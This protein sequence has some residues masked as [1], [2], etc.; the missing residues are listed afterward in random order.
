MI[1]PATSSR[2]RSIALL[3]IGFALATVAFATPASG[4]V[5]GTAEHLLKHLRPKTDARYYTKPAADAQFIKQS[6]AAGGDLAGTFPNPTIAANA[7]GSAEIG[8]SA[9][10]SVEIEDRQ[11]KGDDLAFN[12]I[13]GSALI[14]SGAV[15]S[16]DIQDGTIAS[17]D[18]NGGSVGATQLSGHVAVRTGSVLVPGNTPQNGSYET[19]RAIVVCQADE[20]RVGGG[21]GWYPDTGNDELIIVSSRPSGPD[22]WFAR[23]G[24]DVAYDATFSVYV[25]CLTP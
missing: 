16:D 11:V 8:E 23:G 4:H 21:A 20:L 25:V 9:V 17:N 10:G 14:A 15:R 22:G 3:A 24:S 18:L 7:I 5:G 2:W 1:P 19:R 13:N 12:A 6:A